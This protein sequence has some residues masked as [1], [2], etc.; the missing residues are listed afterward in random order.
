MR[1]RVIEHRVA[2]ARQAAAE[3]RV[4][5]LLG[6]ARRLD[7]LRASLAPTEGGTTGAMLQARNELR[8]R[9]GRAEYEMRNPIRRAEDDHQQA[10]SSRL[11]ARAREEG[12]E[13]LRSKAATAEEYFVATR[14]DANRPFRSLKEPRS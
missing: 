10:S 6:V 3:Q 12:A 14:L 9:L 8:S 2:T 5:E 4:A 13:R 7:D 11:L 1:V